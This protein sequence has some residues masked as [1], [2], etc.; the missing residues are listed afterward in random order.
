M[1]AVKLGW[2]QGPAL[3]NIFVSD[4]TVGLVHPQDQFAD[5]TELYG[6]VDMLE[7]WD[8]IQKDLD[9]LERW[10]CANLVMFNKA[11][12]KVLRLGQ[13]NPKHT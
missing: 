4:W 1:L 8:G 10:D 2:V 3:F 6:A 12:C 9:R 5:D 11:K 13:G 7:G